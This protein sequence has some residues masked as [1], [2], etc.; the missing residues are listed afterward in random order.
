MTKQTF[1]FSISLMS[2]FMNPASGQDWQAVASL[3]TARSHFAAGVIGNK[4]YIFGGHDVNDA[5]V[6]STEVLDMA[7]PSFW[8]LLPGTSNDRVNSVIEYAGATLN[9]QL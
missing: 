5:P 8:T 4:I 1:L 9:E 2:A 3:N 6:N 7:Q